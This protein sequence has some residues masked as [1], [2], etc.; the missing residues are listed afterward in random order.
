MPN[1]YTQIHI[2]FVFAVR[3]RKALIQ[4]NS[5]DDLHQYI[6]GIVQNKTHKMLQFNKMP[7][8]LHVLLGFRPDAH[9]SQLIQ[10]VKSESS[11]WINDQQLTPVK[12]N[13]QEGFGAFSYSKS[14]VQNVIR[15]I[16]NQEQ[17]HRIQ[18]FP[19]EY[20]DFLKVVEVEYQERYIFKDPID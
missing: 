16:Q 8:H 18:T 7:D 19:E 17:H 5:K 6:T 3:Y 14:H 10:V 2:Q 4:P 12:F 11:K 13:W 15:Y 1:T 9:M 20:L